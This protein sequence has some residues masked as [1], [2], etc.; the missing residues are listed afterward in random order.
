MNKLYKIHSFYIL[1]ILI[2]IIIILIAVNWGGIENLVNL[3]SFALT[4]SSLILAI[5][6]IIYAVYSNNSFSSNITKLDISS[7][8][9]NNSAAIV[10]NLSNTLL[11]KIDQIPVLLNSIEQKTDATQILI[12]KLNLPN[13]PAP[14]NN[15]DPNTLDLKNF[16]QQ[17]SISGKTLLYILYLSLKAK[18]EFNLK[19]ICDKYSLG[20]N[21][22]YGFFVAVQTLRIIKNNFDYKN[23]GF[24][25]EVLEIN[26]LVKENIIEVI[27]NVKSE[28]ETNSNDSFRTKIKQL[29]EYFEK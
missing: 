10:S 25:Y 28:N 27:E 22:Y 20:Y 1:T 13:D 9:I 16:V 18:K 23:G 17:T 21:Y 15:F 8:K 24:F 12:S 26:S 6:A 5:L 14:D 4:I 3:I 29:E 19:E 7:E 11:E 2:S